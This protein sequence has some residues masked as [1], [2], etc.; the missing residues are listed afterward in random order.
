MCEC[1]AQRALHQSKA[2]SWASMG[3]G[4]VSTMT[5]DILHPASLLSLCY[6]PHGPRLSLA[7]LPGLC[8]WLPSFDCLPVMINYPL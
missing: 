7:A 8:D 4:V 2:E 3:D 6:A 5:Q 1:A